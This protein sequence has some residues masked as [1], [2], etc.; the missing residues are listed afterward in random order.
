[1]VDCKHWSPSKQG[2]GNC[3]DGLYGGRPAINQCMTICEKGP[4]VTNAQFARWIQDKHRVYNRGIPA[5][6]IPGLQ[7]SGGCCG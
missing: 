3:A 7:E 5:R 4:K 1:M 2:G 6:F